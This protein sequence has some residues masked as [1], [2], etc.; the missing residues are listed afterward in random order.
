MLR[1][2]VAPD[3]VGKVIGAAGP[4]RPR[5]AHGRARERGA[6][7]AAACSLEIAGSVAGRGALRH[8]RDAARARGGARRGR[9]RGRR[10]DRLRRRPGR[11]GRYPSET[12]ELLRG[13]GDA[14]AGCA[15]TATAELA[16]RR[17]LGLRERL[18]ASERRCARLAGGDWPLSV[19]GL[20]DV[21]LLP[22]DAASDEEI[23][24]QAHARRSAC[25]GVLAGVDGA[26]RRGRAHAHA[27]RPARR[28][29]CAS[30]TPARS[31]M[32]YEGEVAAFWAL[33]GRRRRAPRDAVR[34]R[35]R[36]REVARAGWPDAEAFVEENLRAP[37]DA[38]ASFFEQRRVDR[39]ERMTEHVG[40]RPRRAGRTALDG[41]FVVEHRE[42]RPGA[43]RGRRDAARRR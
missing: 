31:G 9:R 24:T 16:S 33:L 4:D 41:A 36:D 13:L 39:G 35:A 2:H 30:S 3:D 38:G 12:L 10:R 29:T 22:R 28:A 42:R 37:A 19:V 25:A 15:A 23:V 43:V 8:P 26:R 17:E 20:D 21:A 7:E 6:R 1:L 32:P 11:A 27:V 5:A 14:R 34:R 18:A 40:R